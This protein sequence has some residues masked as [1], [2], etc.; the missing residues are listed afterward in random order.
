MLHTFKANAKKTPIGL[1]VSTTARDFEIR[2]DEP[3]SLGGS[4]KGMNPVEAMLSALGACEVITAAA[5]AKS[6]NFTFED[7]WVELEGDLD[8]AG[9]KGSKHVRNGFQEIRFKMHFKTDETQER[10]EEF[11]RFVESRCPVF[12]N[13]TN[14]V[15]VVCSG[16]VKD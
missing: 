5:F 15:D 9:F 6:Q 4:D 7:C 12:D 16:V 11:T 8:F 13:L 3:K 2:L 14:G 10:C 1:E